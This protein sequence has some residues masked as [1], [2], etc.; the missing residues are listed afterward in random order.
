M[1]TLYELRL[2][3]VERFESL[4][5]DRGQA[6]NRFLWTRLSGDEKLQWREVNYGDE[7]QVV[8][9]YPT[10]PAALRS[11]DAFRMLMVEVHNLRAVLLGNYRN[12]EA[13]INRVLELLN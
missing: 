3:R 10:D 13:Q 9:L 2:T 8:G 12:T 11:D 1:A 6:L 4:L 5:D 7:A